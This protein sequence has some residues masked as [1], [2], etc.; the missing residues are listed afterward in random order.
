MNSMSRHS[1]LPSPTRRDLLAQGLGSGE[2][3]WVDRED[4]TWGGPQEHEGDWDP[5]G[6]V[7]EAEGN[8]GCA[9]HRGGEGKRSARS[10]G[11]RIS[12]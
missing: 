9:D 1:D 5:E 11:L 10:S 2:V 3:H 12:R 8:A 4:R 6:I 7:S